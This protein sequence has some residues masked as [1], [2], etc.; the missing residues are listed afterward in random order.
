[1]LWVVSTAVVCMLSVVCCMLCCM[2]R[3][4]LRVVICALCCV[5]IAPCYVWYV[6]CV[7]HACGVRCVLFGIRCA[8]VIALV[9]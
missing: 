2:L 1:M 9:V 5:C 6:S 8:G 4:A 7:I 3:D